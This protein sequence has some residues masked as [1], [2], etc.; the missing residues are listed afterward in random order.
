[1]N[2]PNLIYWAKCAVVL[3]AIPLAIR[4]YSGGPPQRVT[5]A[6]G[7]GTCNQSGCH[8]GTPVNSAFG[9]VQITYSGGST[10]TPGERGKFTVVITD[11]TARAYGFQASARLASDLT[12]GQA[13]TL[14]AGPAML[15]QCADGR[16]LPC[17]PDSAVQFINH[18][19]PAAA[20]RFEFDWTAPAANSGNVTVYVSGNGA[21]G[22]RS[23][24]GD[25]IYTASVTLTPAAGT[26]AQRP[27]VTSGGVANTWS[28][29]PTIATNTWISIFGSNFSTETRTWD[30]SPEFAQNRLPMSL[31]GV[32][33]TIGGRAAPV[34]F[35]SPGQV[36]ALVPDDTA[37]GNQ[38]LVVI[39]SAGEST[40][41]TIVRQNL[42]PGLLTTTSEGRLRVIG[43]LNS[44]ANVVLGL[45]NR[46]FRVGELVQFY[47]TGLGPTTP[48]IPIEN[49]VQT[50]AN[51]V[52]TP[53]IRIN[54]VP[55]SVVGS[56]FVG[57]GLYQINATIP[58]LPT[59]EHTV[60]IE[61][62]GTQSPQ[63]PQAITILVQRP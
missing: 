25:R 43:R 24:G 62:G 57:S 16:D 1:M 46:P 61:A 26:P 10:Y 58:D 5:G 59:G 42:S 18:S 38:P 29:S 13:G 50:P 37:T 2:R 41:V 47:A 39:N 9:N 22:N 35:I 28:A 54:N 4:A 15:V 11:Q 21:N 49:V 36:N 3:T 20:G 7:D 53:A 34:Y 17:R 27:A 44:D 23:Q 33:V 52:N 55:V 30:G 40:P 19:A 14:I 32:R 8:V 51:L 63:T 48:V 60:I 31:G 12:N 45:P 6:P 56:A